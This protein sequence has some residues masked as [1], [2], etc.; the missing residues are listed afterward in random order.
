[1]VCLALI[2]V[3]VVLGLPIAAIALALRV[4]RETRALRDAITRLE[5]AV[6]MQALAAQADAEAAQIERVDK[7]ASTGADPLVS[8]APA[9]DFSAPRAAPH[10]A[11]LEAAPSWSG[12]AAPDLARPAQPAD[13]AAAEKPA[14]TMGPDAAGPHVMAVETEQSE[15]LEAT[16]ATRLATWLGAIALF[17]AAGFFVKWTFDAGLLGPAVRCALGA[18]FGGLLVA[19]GELLRRRDARVA[20]GTTAAGLAALYA[21]V[22]AALN[23]YQLVSPTVGFALLAAITAAAVFLALR[24]GPFVAILSLLGGF[25]TPGL[26]E[27]REPRALPLFG[28]LLLLQV[29]LGV[30]ARRRAWS[31]LGL[32]ASLATSAWVILWANT[33]Y[34][35]ADAPTLGMFVVAGLALLVL[36]TGSLRVRDAAADPIVGAM[37]TAASLAALLALA[38]VTSVGHYSLTNWCFVGLLSIGAI[39]IARIDRHCEPL[40]WLAACGVA[41]MLAGWPAAGQASDPGLFSWV[42]LGFGLVFGVGSYV[43]MWGAPVPMR[44]SLLTVASSLA[45]LGLAYQALAQ[46]PPGGWAAWCAAAAAGHALLAVPLARRSVRLW[47]GDPPL[48]LMLIGATAFVSIGCVIELDARHLPIALALEGSMVALI[49][50]WLRVAMLPE[51]SIV[52]TAGSVAAALLAVIQGGAVAGGAVFNELLPM[53]GA[54]LVAAGVAAYVM[55]RCKHP[56][57]GEL[58][59]WVAVIAAAMLA[60]LDVRHAFNP[61]DAPAV[62]PPGLGESAGYVIV[63]LALAL[64]AGLVSWIAARSVLRQAAPLLMYAA[65][66]TAGLLLLLVNNPFWSHTAVGAAAVVNGLLVYYGLPALLLAAAACVFASWGETL[67]ARVAQAAGVAFLFLLITYEVRHWFHGEAME[68]ALLRDLKLRHIKAPLAEAAAYVNAWLCM[69]LACGWCARFAAREVLP[70]AA[71]CLAWV[72]LAAAGTQLLLVNNPLWTDASVGPTLILNGL[73]A[74][75]GL[76][77]LLLALASRMLR[78]WRAAFAAKVAAVAALVFLFTLTSLEV[79][80][81]F[82][83][84]NLQLERPTSAAE[85]YAHSAAWILLGLSLMAAGARGRSQTT[86]WAS[87]AVMLLAVGK[88][89]LVDTAHLRDL[90]RVFSLLGLGASLMLLAFVYRRWVF[91]PRAGAS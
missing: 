77:A 54:P 75:Y 36:S 61:A 6:A 91:R 63:G 3:A 78:G 52:L 2:A 47:L 74:A 43:A 21:V 22:L 46:P 23:L 5:H 89:F 51:V 31:W 39:A 38:Q 81:W 42:V 35:P 83:G 44:W 8:A 82:Q 76:P 15:A 27:S 34:L 28:Y 32:V 64:L 26:I 84:G 59:E 53:L 85:S 37:R 79:R 60:A 90:Y 25:V 30:V 55:Q 66:A 65:L 49:F 29:G 57:I 24:H 45:A 67:L 16:V 20:E 10:A 14:S 41:L 13:T 1:M 48:A 56:A 58:H 19:A 70:H 62:W 7:V 73:L 69:G 18:A 9:S 11:P 12:D 68:F 88:V 17:L 86:R 33:H 50:A 71:Q 87:L 72:A 80:Q 40:A 4:E